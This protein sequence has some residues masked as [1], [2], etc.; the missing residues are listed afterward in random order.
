MAI[1]ANNAAHVTY[2]PE[3]LDNGDGQYARPYSQLAYATNR[4]G[5]WTTQIVHQPQDDSGD[6][7]CGASIAIA[8]DGLPAIAQFFVDRVLDGLGQCGPT[9]VS[10]AAE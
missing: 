9:S 10:Q 7:G 5:A 8:P 4:S 3:F 6:S 2:T 1:D